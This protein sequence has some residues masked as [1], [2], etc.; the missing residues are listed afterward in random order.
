MFRRPAVALVALLV[1]LIPTG[2]AGAA[3]AV[4]HPTPHQVERFW[5]PGRMAAARPLELTVGRDG[6]GRV[7]LGPRSRAARAS[8]SVVETPEVPPFA[9]NGRLYVRQA[10]EEGFCSATAIDSASRR[11]V[12]TAGH[13][14][15][16]G[17]QDGKPGAW[18]TYLE[19]VPGFNLGA[20]PYGTFVLSGR[21][22]A[23]PGW[24]ED[25]NPDFDLGAFLT[26]PNAEGAAVADAVGGGATIVT[27]RGRRQ[28]F[29]TFGYPGGTERMRTCVSGFAG[30]DQVT[31]TLAGP[32]TVGIRCD[33][34]PGA[35][36]GSWLID[37]G[38]AIDGLTSYIV[39][40][41]KAQR[42]YGPYFSASTVGRLVA[43]L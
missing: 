20:A 22:R 38:T 37:G 10:G 12:L 4:A 5:T 11:L 36:G 33:W 41:G 42:T 24:I 18:S 16:S 32:S 9:W 28:R 34:A 29:E 27:D 17:P 21:P 39:G 1:V 30:T 19:F 35:S 23:L 14:V 31:A 7:E 26:E 8:Y 15:N 25:G 13:C 2:S 6:R 43:G 40:E 3:P